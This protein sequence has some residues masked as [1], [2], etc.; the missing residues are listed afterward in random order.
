[1]ERNLI[2]QFN[3]DNSYNIKSICFRAFA[4]SF[5]ISTI[6]FLLTFLGDKASAE[7][8]LLRFVFILIFVTAVILIP[9]V[10]FIERRLRMEKGVMLEAMGEYT[11]AMM[12]ASKYAS[13]NQIAKFRAAYEIELKQSHLS[14]QV[15]QTTSSQAHSTSNNQINPTIH[16]HN[17]QSNQG[18]TQNYIQDSV[19]TDWNQR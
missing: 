13:P 7:D 8:L 15:V 1:M 14:E 11:E 17:S 9:F 4:S 19:V 5:I 3:V 10:H 6:I 16:I 18:P 2:L 12:I